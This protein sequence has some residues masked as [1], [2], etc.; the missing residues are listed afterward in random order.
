MKLYPY[1]QPFAKLSR[2]KENIIYKGIIDV[3]RRKAIGFVDMCKASRR[4]KACNV[5]CGPPQPNIEH[6]YSQKKLVCGK[7]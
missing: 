3:K 5:L 6:W 2:N 4:L 1:I 7:N